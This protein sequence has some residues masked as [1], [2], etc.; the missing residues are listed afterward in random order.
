MSG[1]VLNAVSVSAALTASLRE[2]ILSGEIAPGTA[3]PETELAVTYR[4]ARP[5]V[6]AALQDLVGMGLLR[7]EPNRSAYVPTLSAEDVTDLFLVRRGLECDAVRIL[8]ARR[9]RPPRAE[10]AV[11]S[12]EAF[13]ESAEW[14]AVVDSDLAF[15][16]ALIEAVGS[17]RLVRLHALLHDEI[18]LSLAQ[19]RPAYESPTALASEHRALLEGIAAGDSDRAVALLEEHLNHAVVALTSR[20][21]A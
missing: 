17:P 8:V 7:R 3:L 15:H 12:L 13:R 1:P 2:R 5:T 6:R 20:A 14:S 16:R 19:L 10:Q 21:A 11:R 4:V 18:R 9:A